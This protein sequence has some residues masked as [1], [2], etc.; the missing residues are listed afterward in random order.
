MLFCRIS[1]SYY[2]SCVFSKF[3]LA[4]SDTTKIQQ[5]CSN[6]EGIWYFKCH[7]FFL[8]PF[9]L[10]PYTN[11][12]LKSN[13]QIKKVYIFSIRKSY[14]IHNFYQIKIFYFKIHGIR[15]IYSQEGRNIKIK[16][17]LLSKQ[18][19]GSFGQ[20]EASVWNILLV[21]KVLIFI[22]WPIANTRLDKRGG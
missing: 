14:I 13:L 9:Q 8:Y 5:V 12:M 7:R 4:F 17:T 3:L 22:Q 18:S 11:L 15:K 2:K 21:N 20:L 6:A 16:K 10:L 19:L 1:N